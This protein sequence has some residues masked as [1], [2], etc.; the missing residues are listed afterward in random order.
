[1]GLNKSYFTTFVLSFYRPSSFFFSP[2]KNIGREKKEER[3]YKILTLY[4]IVLML[5]LINNMINWQ[6][7][8]HI[9]TKRNVQ[10]MQICVQQCTIHVQ[11]VAKVE[12][13]GSLF[14]H[15]GVHS[16]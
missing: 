11:L 9:E 15:L 10:F 4:I 14:K 7:T 12:T 8:D 2:F 16:N 13:Q 6:K 5:G 1:L 3:Q